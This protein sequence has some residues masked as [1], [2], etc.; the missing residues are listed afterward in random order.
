[1]NF[2]TL[3]IRLTRPEVVCL[4]FSELSG[5]IVLIK[6]CFWCFTASV[7]MFPRPRNSPCFLPTTY[8]S[9]PASSLQRQRRLAQ[10]DPRPV[11][12]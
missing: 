5:N 2:S 10:I 6:L 7:A 8:L 3:G 1:M 9:L 11:E 12:D 4:N